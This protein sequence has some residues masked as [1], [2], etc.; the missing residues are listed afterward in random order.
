MN[1]K[2]IVG[3]YQRLT[4]EDVEKRIGEIREAAA[5]GDDEKAHAME[6]DLAWIVIRK[7]AYRGSRIAR[8]ALASRG[9][10]IQRHCA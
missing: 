3:G 5:M 10:K 1:E 6:D 7:M 9:I 8:A 4:V 2:M